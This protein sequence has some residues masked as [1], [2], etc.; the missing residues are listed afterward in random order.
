[1]HRREFVRGEKRIEVLFADYRP[2][3]AVGPFGVGRVR[4]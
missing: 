2:V 1:M 3:R 4:D